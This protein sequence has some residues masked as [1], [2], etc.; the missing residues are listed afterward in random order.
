M[1]D[2]PSVVIAARDEPL[3]AETVA[4]VLDELPPNGEIVVV[5]DS[6]RNG[7]AAEVASLDPRVRVHRPPRRLGVAGARNLGARIARRDVLVFADA[8]VRPRPG[9]RA[10]VREL[11]DPT[12]GATGPTL[13]DGST[14]STGRGLR[15]CDAATRTAWLED[16]GLAPYA[17]PLLPGF[18]VVMRRQVFVSIGGFDAG[19]VG[20]GVDDI[21]LSMHL[22]TLGYRCVVVPQVEVVHAPADGV[23]PDYHLEWEPLLRNILRLGGVHFGDARLKELHDAYRADNAFEPA[24]AAVAAGDVARRREAVQR[25]RRFDDD[26]FFRWCGVISA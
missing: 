2:A 26:W 20:W 18:F 17:V 8:H 3:L 19:L 7:S 4:S 15:L 23:T 12:V 9:W 25:A 16:R 6:S 21:E 13:V 5:D 10:L 24:L 22:A 14:G 1:S 11:A